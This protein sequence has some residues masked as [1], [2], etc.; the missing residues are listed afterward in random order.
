MMRLRKNIEA[1]IIFVKPKIGKFCKK[2][3]KKLFFSAFPG[4]PVL[5]LL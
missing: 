1:F 4:R 2:I 3:K 5:V